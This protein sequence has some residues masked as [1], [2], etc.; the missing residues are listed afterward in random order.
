VLFPYVGE[1]LTVQYSS[2]LRTV[3]R[4]DKSASQHRA[5]VVVKSM[6]PRSATAS[7]AAV[8]AVRV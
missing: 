4:A 5:R 8:V 2:G 6:T 1:E 7:T 3:W